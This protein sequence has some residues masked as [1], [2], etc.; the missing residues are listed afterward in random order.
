[1]QNCVGSL[2]IIAVARSS[3]HGI[4]NRARYQKLYPHGCLEV[5]VSTTLC[6]ET[7]LQREI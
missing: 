1:M 6:H 3:Q 7:D 4:W 5:F 2:L